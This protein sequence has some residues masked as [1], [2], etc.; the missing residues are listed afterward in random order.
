V[1]IDGGRINTRTAGL[2]PGVHE[3][4][5]RETKNAGFFRMRG[6]RFVK[7][8]HPE[9]PSCFSSKKQMQS[10]LSGLSDE[11]VSEEPSHTKPDFSWRPKSLVRTCISSLCSS[12]RFGELMSAEAENRGFYSANRR[13][14][15]GDGLGYNWSIQQTHFEKF[16]PI[17]DIIHPIERLHELSRVLYSESPE[18]AWHECLRWIELCWSGDATELIGLLEAQQLDVGYPE[19]DTPEDDP[20]I[21][22]AETVGYLKNNLSRMN[23][24]SY[25]REGLPISSCLIE[26]QVKE[27][28][29]RIK[30]TEKFWDDGDGGEAI[31]QIRAAII[32]DGE[33]LHNYIR[34]RPGNQ[35]TRKSRKNKKTALT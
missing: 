19:E 5:W 1:Q 23:Y 12:D 17:L 4:H 10:L 28:N 16:T 26:S 31:C 13:A 3:P 18:E 14:F 20:R 7:D 11:A 8:P 21:K 33:Q 2:G 25:R 22:L 35:Y 6:E 24:P 34:S 15:L 30:G 29:H 27:M 9:L 32:S